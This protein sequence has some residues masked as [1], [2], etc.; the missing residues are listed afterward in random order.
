MIIL[1]II[2]FCKSTDSTEK[3]LKSERTIYIYIY[4]Y[5]NTHTHTHTHIYIYIYIY[6][7]IISSVT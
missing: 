4:I 1:I 6:I 7:Y 5:I 2:S 3:N